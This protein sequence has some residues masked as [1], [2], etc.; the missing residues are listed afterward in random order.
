MQRPR[1]LPAAFAVVVLVVAQLIGLAHQAN[2][3]HI[4]CAEHGEQL[5]AATLVGQSNGCSDSHWIGVEGDAGG[6]TECALTRVLHQSVTASKVLLVATSITTT[7]AVSTMPAAPLVRQTDL[8]L[9]A[10]K[11]S[12]PA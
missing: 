7:A 5:E 4:V 6:H 9:A 8:Y 1:A 2:Q 3:R 11:T 12:P 10:P